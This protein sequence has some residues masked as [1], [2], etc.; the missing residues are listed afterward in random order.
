MQPFTLIFYRFL[1]GFTVLTVLLFPKLLKVNKAT[2]KYSF[3][4]GAIIST[5]LFLII[6]S[7]KYTTATT[8]GFLT[9]SAVA[10]VI[11]IDCILKKQF[12]KLEVAV[13]L[14]L[15]TIGLYLLTVN[16]EGIKLNFGALLS[17]MG[18]IGYAMHIH[19]VNYWSH[20]VDT[21]AFSIV[22]LGWVVVFSSILAFGIEPIANPLNW[23]A[24]AWEAMLGLAIICTA[25]CFFIQIVA[26]KYSTATQ[27]GLLFT[28]E[29]VFSAF[30]ASL[31]LGEV[32]T[33]RTFIGATLVLTGVIVSMLFT[34]KRKKCMS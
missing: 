19:L 3:V 28:F 26:Q 24:H 32:L 6:L 8:V 33:K 21:V 34:Y 17:L 14:C 23:S 2:L 4:G 10:M 5:L 20:K 27:T 15:V 9:S 11:L 25:Y 13:G 22:Q 1:I 31:I 7:L 18:A 30:Y 29:P 12:P 16:G